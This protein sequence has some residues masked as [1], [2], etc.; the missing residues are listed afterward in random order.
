MPG[1]GHPGHF[2]K[3]PGWVDRPGSPTA[4]PPK[5]A[6]R[7]SAGT[8]SSKATEAQAKVDE[9]LGK[10]N[11]DEKV[12]EAAEAVEHD[13]DTLGAIQAERDEYL[14]SLRRLQADFENYKKRIARQQAEAQERAA[15]KLVEKLLPV[16]DNFDLALSHG[17]AA[18]GLEPIY[19][20][21]LGTLGSAGLER[22]D[23]AGQPF[24]PNEHDAVLHEEGDADAPEVIEVMRAGYRWKGRV[25]RPAM[26]K[27]KG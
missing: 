10:G 1:P 6:P 18:G 13:I 24:D 23:P 27:V 14:D 20:N 11:D 26:V 19:R 2:P 21:L 7:P 17:D 8:P 9:L 3:P 16:L 12:E 22:L 15:E 4:P 5:T 25:L